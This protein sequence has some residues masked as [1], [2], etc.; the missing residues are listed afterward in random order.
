MSCGSARCSSAG[1]NPVKTQQAEVQDLQRRVQTRADDP[2][3]KTGTKTQKLARFV[4]ALA[5][6]YLQ[7]K[8]AMRQMGPA[9]TARMTSR[10]T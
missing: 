10:P 2:D 9:G 1:G 6:T 8:A 3:P 7:R 4:N 5:E